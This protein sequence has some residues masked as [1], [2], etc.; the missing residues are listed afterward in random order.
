MGWYVD[1][2]LAKLISQWKAEH[3][4]AVVGTI[5]DQAHQVEYSEHN[6]EA[7]G[8]VDAGD[9]MPGNGVTDADLTQLA[10]ALAAHRDKRLLYVIWQQR[11]FSNNDGDADWAWRHYDY[12]YHDHVHVSVNDKY[13]TD[14]SEWNLG[15][16][17]DMELTDN[18]YTGT[19]SSSW[20]NR[21]GTAAATV[22]NGLA[23]GAFYAY[24]SAKAAAETNKRLDRIIELLEAQAKK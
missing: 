2:G 16:E 19:P 8:S 4:G 22:R 24:D 9:F 23:F 3:P 20:T 12:E 1:P 7:D 15:E 10:N 18:I 17:D 13:E 5:G 6:P 14:S 11:I 21:F